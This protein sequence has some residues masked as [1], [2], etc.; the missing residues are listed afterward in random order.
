MKKVLQGTFYFI[1][2]IAIIIAM[3][4]LGASD[5]TGYG[6]NVVAF[7]V[8]VAGAGIGVGTLFN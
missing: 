2:F 8:G 6:Y 5:L 7:C 1:A 4:L 3:V